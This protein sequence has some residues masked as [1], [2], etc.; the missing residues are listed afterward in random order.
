M[1][2]P[3]NIKERRK[4]LGLTLADVAKMVGVTEDTVERV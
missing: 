3:Q 1:G 4:E 2:L